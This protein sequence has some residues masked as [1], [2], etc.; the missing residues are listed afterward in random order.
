MLVY[1][2]IRVMLA[3]DGTVDYVQ[4]IPYPNQAQCQRVADAYAHSIH[5]ARCQRLYIEPGMARVVI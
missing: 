4:Q 2:L 3:P 5:Y 1:I